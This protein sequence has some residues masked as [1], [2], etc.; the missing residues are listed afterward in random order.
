MV[1]SIEIFS[2]IKWTGI[3]FVLDIVFRFSIRFILAT[4]LLPN[5]FGLVGMC[6][7]FISVAGA[8]SELGLS[9]ALIQKKNDEEARE[10]YSTAFW[11]C[12]IWGLI[13]FLILSFVIGPFAASFYE[14]QI[15]NLLIPVLSLGILIK[16]FGLIHQVILTRK[17]DFK[18]L[19]K[20][21][22]ISTFIAGIF[23]I[24]GAYMFNLGVWALIINSLFS[25]I[26]SLP[27]LFVKTKWKP[28]IEWNKLHFKNIFGFGA[29]SSGTVMF[30]TLTYN[31]DNLIIGKLLGSSLLGA[32]TLSFSLTEQFRQAISGIINKVMYPVFGKTQDDKDKVKGYFLKIININ[33]ILIYPIMSFFFYFS[34][35]IILSFFGE[36]WIESI[37][38]LKILSI[39]MMVHLLV[40]SFTSLIRG[41]GKPKLEMKII[42]GLTIFILIP[43]LYL[44]IK[45]F[46]LTGAAFAILLNKVCLATVGLFILNREISVSLLNVYHSV[47]GAIF[48][49][50]ITSLSVLLAEKYLYNNSIFLFGVFILTYIFVIY[51][52][53]NKN[54][55]A[56]IYNLK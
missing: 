16:P 20:I 11:S 54:I 21:L 8:A 52:F 29:Y 2:G 45:N 13:I 51:K 7:I 42:I 5:E 14:E 41:L 30:S 28:R 50:L 46:G 44:G 1:K 27:L 40:N 37:I 12:L 3:Q 47:K 10:M 56:L 24:I 26:I 23:S 17:M 25:I 53:E 34:E 18:S 43:G 9:A 55:K 4:L 22:N 39:G 15:L 49:I 38:P 6:T 31:I 35:E 19:A 36:K 33:A 32:Y 48:S